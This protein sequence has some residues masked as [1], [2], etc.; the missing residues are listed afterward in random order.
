MI[1]TDRV[2][3]LS[4]INNLTEEMY[5]YK[6]KSKDTKRIVSNAGFNTKKALEQPCYYNNKE[7]YEVVKK[8]DSYKQKLEGLIIQDLICAISP[9]YRFDQIFLEEIGFRKC[10]KCF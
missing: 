1:T 9:E 10:S 4:N 7:V 8:W 3:V 2:Q 5:L 6:E